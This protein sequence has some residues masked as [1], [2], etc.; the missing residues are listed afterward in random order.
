MSTPSPPSF[1][2]LALGVALAMLALTL[3]S[4]TASASSPRAVDSLRTTAAHP[5]SVTANAGLG[6]PTGFFGLG[7]GYHFTPEW[8]LEAGL[9]VGV[10]GYQLALTARYALPIGS[11]G[12]HGLIFGLGP[13]IALR[14]DATWLTGIEHTADVTIA[15]AHLYHTLWLNAEIGWEGRLRWRLLSWM[16]TMVVRVLLGAS[17]R[18]ADN[19]RHLCDGADDSATGCHEVPLIPSGA[20][21]ADQAVMPYRQ[22]SGGWAF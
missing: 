19:Q 10:T 6:G 2:N 4:P 14:S 1:P 16:P 7:V 3:P 20:W 12:Q 18:M 5:F 17:V 22:F 21:V 9:G 13:S 15:R 11:S 8:Q